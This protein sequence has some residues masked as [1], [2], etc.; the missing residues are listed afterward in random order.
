[1]SACTN[2]QLLLDHLGK[3]PTKISSKKNDLFLPFHLQS[4]KVMTS[5]NFCQIDWVVFPQPF[6]KYWRM[7]N[8]VIISPKGLRWKKCSNTH[9]CQPVHHTS[10]RNPSNGDHGHYTVTWGADLFSVHCASWWREDVGLLLGDVGD[11]RPRLNLLNPFLENSYLSM[12][13]KSG[14]RQP[15]GMHNKPCMGST[16]LNW[17]TPVLNVYL[18]RRCKC[19]KC[20]KDKIQR[21]SWHRL[22][23]VVDWL[24][25]T[26]VFVV[27]HAGM[28]A[29]P[30]CENIVIQN[31]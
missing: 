13:Q 8:W 31:T 1:M 15:P 20:V 21:L 2:L 17:W 3:L 30:P 14:A 5:T 12:V 24:L 22:F 7:S 18:P 9:L 6:A 28:G 19:E 23:R 11:L 16:N 10:P 25:V 29:H 26:N 27:W 4:Y